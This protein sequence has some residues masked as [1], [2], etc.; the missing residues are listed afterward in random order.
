MNPN[1]KQ[2]TLSDTTII[3]LHLDQAEIVKSSS[4]TAGEIVALADLPKWRGWGMAKR[5]LECAYK[6]LRDVV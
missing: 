3:G 5:A 1:A 6:N 4:K 2:V